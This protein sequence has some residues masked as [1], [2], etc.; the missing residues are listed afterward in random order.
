MAA[1]HELSA[2]TPELLGA[3]ERLFAHPVETDP[4]CWGKT[5]IAETLSQLD[6]NES[7][8]FLRGASHVQLE[9]VWGGQEDA[10]VP[11]RA[12][13]ALALVQ[14]HDLNRVETFRHLVDALADSAAPVRL[15]AVGAV[16]Q[17]GGEGAL[18]LLRMKAH[19]GDRRAAVIGQVFDSLLA[20]DPE[21]SL[22][23][24][25]RFS[26]SSS[27]ETRDEA[28]LALGTSRLQDAVEF[29]IG[30]WEEARD[31]GY[32]RTILRALSS[33]RR[34]SVI[35]FLLDLV[36]NKPARDEGLQVAR[37]LHR[38]IYEVRADG[39]N[40]TFRILFAPEGKKG[41][42]LLALEGFSKKTRKTPRRLIEVAERRLA[43]WRTRG[44][45]G[46]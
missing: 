12:A 17:M 38:E 9:P 13:C 37:H 32:R 24:V 22:S 39:R 5:A 46:T 43:E 2:L 18:L 27:A 11:L 3:Y 23:F 33:S 14:C 15:E 19:T 1:G 28:A 34:E 20:L 45:R 41:R 35:E 8:P 31:D 40:A 29:L 44:H 6:Y 42:V 16:E 26:E 7:A 30:A 10:A 4:Q 36:R 25:T 21:T